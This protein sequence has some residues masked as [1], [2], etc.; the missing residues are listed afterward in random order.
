MEGINELV[1]LKLAFW[2]K[3]N[4]S[5]HEKVAKFKGICCFYLSPNK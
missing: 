4:L 2:C 1:E 5:R 3:P